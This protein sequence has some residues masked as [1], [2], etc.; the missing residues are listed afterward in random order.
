MSALAQ[1][2]TDDDECECRIVP[3]AD[4]ALRDFGIDLTF[5]KFRAVQLL[6]RFEQSMR[7][8]RRLH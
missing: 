6:S 5:N 7:P 1:K 3:G 4:I 8:F 2:L